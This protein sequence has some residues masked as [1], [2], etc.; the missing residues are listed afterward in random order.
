[1]KMV[2]LIALSDPARDDSAGLVTA[3]A[4]A[5]ACAP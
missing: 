1:M 4:R 3:L 2:G 5:W